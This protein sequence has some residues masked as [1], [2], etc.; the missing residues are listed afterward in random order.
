MHANSPR[1]AS[2]NPM[3]TQPRGRVDNSRATEHQDVENWLGSFSGT[4]DVVAAVQIEQLS[5]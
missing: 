5:C 2:E 4:A 1:V 3:H